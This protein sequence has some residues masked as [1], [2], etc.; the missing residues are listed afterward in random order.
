[1]KN[2]EY[3]IPLIDMNRWRFGSDEEK[4]LLAQSIDEHLQKLGFL[5]IKNHGIDESKRVSARDAAMRFFALSESDK[6][7]YTCPEDAYRGWIGPGLESNASSYGVEENGQAIVDLKEAYS[8]GPVFEGAEKLQ[9]AAPRWY[10]NNIWPDKHVSGFKTA[11][12]D[13]WHA[14]DALTLE[15]L[16]ILATVLDLESTWVNDSCDHPMATITTNLY[17]S[18]DENGGWRVGEHTDFGTITL[19]D[20]DADNG[21]QIEV[22]K[23]QWIEAPVVKGTLIVNLGEMMVNIS[24]GRWKANPHRV[25]AHPNDSENLSLVYFHDPNFDLELPITKEDGSAMTA[26]DFLQIKMD[27]IIQNSV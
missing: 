13:W 20:R 27:Q 11:M 15:I 18:V 16:E 12:I 24:G 19:L 26:A 2:S 1:M 9:A 23:G 22:E 17:P 6:K 14:A 8:I 5:M 25:V 4:T 21:L 10:A 7:L 3:T